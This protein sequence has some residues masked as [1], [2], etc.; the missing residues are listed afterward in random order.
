MLWNRGDEVFRVTARKDQWG[1]V[2]DWICNE[3]RFEKKKTSDWVIEGPTKINRHSVI[4]QGHYVGTK[5][6]PEILPEVMGRDPRIL[7]D[8]HTASNVNR[9]DVD[10]SLIQGPA[11]SDDF[12][13]N[14]NKQL[15]Q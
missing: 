14:S 3:C 2:M 9:P 10:L 13:T 5:E 1:E 8:I 15:P 12:K 11:H 6:P 4:S 7:L